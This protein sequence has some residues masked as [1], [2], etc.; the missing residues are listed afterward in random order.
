MH[1]KITADNRKM[2]VQYIRQS[3]HVLH[4]IVIGNNGF[5]D[6]NSYDRITYLKLLLQWFVDCV[7]G[8]ILLIASFNYQFIALQ[9]AI[10]YPKIMIYVCITDPQRNYILSNTHNTIQIPNGFALLS[11]HCNGEYESKCEKHISI[12]QLEQIDQNEDW[13]ANKAVNPQIY[14]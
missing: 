4:I 2:V 10:C 9:I 7:Y 8:L 6:Y 11:E 3:F 14:D 1:P 13:N 12:E 5:C